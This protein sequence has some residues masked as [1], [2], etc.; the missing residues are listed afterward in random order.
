MNHDVNLHKPRPFVILLTLAVCG[1]CVAA[2]SGNAATAKPGPEL[3]RI[4]LTVHAGFWARKAGTVVGLRLPAEKASAA[5]ARV[6]DAAT[7]KPVPF[8][9]G[10]DE[11][12]ALE[13][14]AF[15]LAKDIPALSTHRYWLVF[16]RGEEETRADDP[17]IPW[18][19]EDCQ[20]LR[21]RNGDF[22]AGDKQAPGWSL[23]RGKVSTDRPHS[24]LR[25]VRL[26][27]D[28]DDKRGA[29][30]TSKRFPLLANCTYTIRFWVRGEKIGEDG[31]L[32]VG[33][34]NFR[35]EDGRSVKGLP[36]R[37]HTGAR[38]LADEWTQISITGPSHPDTRLGQVDIGIY[39]ARGTLCIDDV[40]VWEAVSG[41]LD[42]PA[43]T[44]GD[45]D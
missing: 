3:L 18:P 43:V 22:E 20:L 33:N 13:R 9:R 7:R 6:V 2:S 1:A 44:V 28:G 29:R 16:S 24:G 42:P 23:F 5:G 30:L 8:R 11:K 38:N 4:S 45:G 37:L 14:V 34:L 25:C 15:R 10:P 35:R 21:R 39:R 32:L 12:G 27:Y 41:R 19:Q 36:Y 17:S 26:H 40:E 31:H